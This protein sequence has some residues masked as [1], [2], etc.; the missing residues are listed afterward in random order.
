MN[1]LNNDFQLILFSFLRLKTNM[2]QERDPK[3]HAFL[4]DKRHRSIT[5]MKCVKINVI[6]IL[7]PIFYLY[8]HFDIYLNQNKVYL[9][10]LRL[11]FK[12]RLF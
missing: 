5:F 8:Q 3:T 10:Y 4:E 9:G 2:R 6:L 1:D 7:V 11:S 12:S